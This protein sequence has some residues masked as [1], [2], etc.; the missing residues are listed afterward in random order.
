[1]TV[2]KD[3]R[4]GNYCYRFA[5][6]GV[7]YHRCFKT[8]K[9][10][11]V[12]ALETVAKSELIKTGYDISQN[13]KYSLSELIED[14]KKYAD[15]NYS[16]PEDA[17]KNA[18]DFYNVVGNKLAEEI[19]LSD[20]EK[21]RSFK[22]KNNKNI[23]N[24]TINRCVDDIKRIFSL[25]KSNK[26]I[27][28]NPCDDLTKLKTTNPTKRYL[29]KE[30]E[31]KLLDVCNPMMK[32][33]IITALH[34][35]MRS[36]EIKNLKWGDVFIHQKYLIALNTKNG[37]SREL[38]ITKQMESILNS[39]PKIN[40]YVFCN[41]ITKEPYKDFKTTFSRAV[42]NAGIPH[43]TF[44]ELR[45]STASRLNELGVDIATIQEYL[46]HSDIR[47]TRG[48]IHSNRENIKSAIKKLSEY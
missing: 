46:D 22:K 33:I 23:S 8:L 5:L 15:N 11:E 3:K 26:K 37:K 32:A 20:F 16:R 30:E 9:E 44:H 31:K 42:K 13:I 41:P 1:M 39:L 2:Y 10:K 35:G 19:N 14:Y 24:N 25:A 40:E 12:E 48:Y 6:N 38:V 4:T 17:K 29:T 7:R 21:Y 43:I 34:T 28:Y 18:D 47:T 45:H 27:R 36:S